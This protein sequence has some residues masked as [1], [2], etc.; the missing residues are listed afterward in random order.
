MYEGQQPSTHLMAYGESD[1]KFVA[2]PTLFQDNDGMWYQPDDPFREAI[3]TKEIYQFDTEQEAKEFA[4]P[5][6]S[7]KNK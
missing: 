1:G 2:F 6:A 7:W 3:K 4:G 5:N